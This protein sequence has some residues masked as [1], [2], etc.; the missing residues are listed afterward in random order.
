VKKLVRGIS[1][2]FLLAAAQPIR[3]WLR[4]FSG[5]PPEWEFVPEGW[6]CANDHIR[7]WDVDSVLNAY[8]VKLP[9]VRQALDGPGPIGFPTSAGLPIGQA[10][11]TQQNTLLAFAYC[12]LLASRRQDRISV[13]DWGGGLGYFY[14]LSRALLPSD[15]EIEYHC[16]DV[17]LICRYGREALPEITFWDDESCLLREYDFV[18]ASSSL[19]YCEPWKDLVGRL[20]HCSRSYLFLTRVPVVLQSASFVALQRAWGYAFETELLSWVFNRQEL[21]DAVA[22]SSMALV[23][24]FLLWGQPRVAGAPEQQEIR[25]YLFRRT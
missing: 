14:F 4:R 25:G 23:R 18:C 16:K 12:L 15:V 13:L 6:A 11:I 22:D 7:G 1:P 5:R 10:N 21:F 3:R 24:E 8:R 19:Q 17:P 20:A 9:A 2:P